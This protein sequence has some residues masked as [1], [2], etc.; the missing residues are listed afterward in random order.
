M[1]IIVIGASGTIGRAVANALEGRHEVVRASAGKS[2][3]KVDLGS[4]ESLA[5]MFRT[6]GRVDGVICAAGLAAFNPLTELTDKDFA[7]SC[8]NKLMGQVNLVRTGLDYISDRGVIILTAGIL[9]RR[10]M[11]GSAAISMVNAGLEGFCRAAALELP[12]GIRLNVV[13]PGWVTETLKL[14]KMD[15]AGGTPA[16]AVARTYV[17]ALEGGMNGEV[18]DAIEAEAAAGAR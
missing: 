12:R 17:K 3:V 7:L 16:E 14:Y 4:K 9:S 18:L 10:P 11:K 5:A 8:G 6:V 2:P 15:P 1:K 13:S